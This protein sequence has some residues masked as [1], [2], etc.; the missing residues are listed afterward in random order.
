MQRF[1]QEIPLRLQFVPSTLEQKEHLTKA[2]GK[3]W[4]LKIANEFPTLGWITMQDAFTQMQARFEG[5]DI[6]LKEVLRAL[7]LL[8]VAGV[9]PLTFNRLKGVL[10]VI[11]KRNYQDINLNNSLELLAGQDFI[12][13][14]GTQDPVR[15][16]PAY[17]K[18]CVSYIQLQFF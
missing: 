7:K 13:K 12:E 4:D 1:Y 5:L 3:I 17:L 8:F 14:P 11:C 16:E 6:S 15:P 9:T 18:Y 10:E 2:I